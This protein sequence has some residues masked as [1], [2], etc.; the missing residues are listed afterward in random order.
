[1]AGRADRARWARCRRFT[2]L[3]VI[4]GGWMAL[5]TWG[6]LHGVDPY[7]VSLPALPRQRRCS[8]C[9][10]P[11]D[12]WS[13]ARS[14][15]GGRPPEQVQTYENAEADLRAGGGPAGASSTGT[16][17]RSRGVSLLGVEPGIPGSSGYTGWSRRPGHR[18]RRY[19]QSAP[20]AA[21]LTKGLAPRGP[22]TWRPAPSRLDRAGRRR[23][24]SGST[25][26]RSPSCRSCPLLASSSS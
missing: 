8:S 9:S 5:A 1:M 21:W 17:G 13:P 23:A 6:P 19:R 16:I 14:R 25:R 10:V 15:R 20:S 4:V 24:F 18:T 26:I 12:P 3:L 22:S 7:P 2:P 11:G